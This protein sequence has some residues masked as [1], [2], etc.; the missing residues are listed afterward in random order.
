MKKILMVAAAL[1]MVALQAGCDSDRPSSFVGHWVEVKEEG[2]PPMTLDISL[3]ERVFHI[4]EKKN[5]FGK[6]FERKLEGT[7][8]SDTTLSILGGALTMR[9][10]NN[11]LH[12]SG[13]E[14]VKSP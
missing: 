14:L 12:Y 1:V 3:N 11:R 9:L 6:N 2:T 4:D 7:A 8:L 13:R 5:V 10:E